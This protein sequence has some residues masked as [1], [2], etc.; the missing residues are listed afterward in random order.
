[1]EFP[2]PLEINMTIVISLKFSWKVHQI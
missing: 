2:F 1:M